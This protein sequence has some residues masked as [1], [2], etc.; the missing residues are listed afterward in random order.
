MKKIIGSIGLVVAIAL[1]LCS[2]SLPASASGSTFVGQKLSIGLEANPTTGYAW[3]MT[4][5]PEYFSLVG[6]EYIPFGGGDQYSSSSMQSGYTAAADLPLIEGS[7]GMMVWTFEAL[8]TG[9]S[10]IVCKYK[11]PWETLPVYR[12]RHVI[13]IKD[14]SP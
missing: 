13:N 2:T 11:R 4:Y 6:Q 1:M 3:N 14:F 12:V 7:G 10:S 8:Q 5:D 9:Q